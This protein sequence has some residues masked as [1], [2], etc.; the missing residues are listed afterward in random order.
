MRYEIVGLCGD[1]VVAAGRIVAT[2]A[3]SLRMTPLVAAE[4]GRPASRGYLGGMQPLRRVVAR[5]READRYGFDLGHDALQAG[6]SGFLLKDVPADQLVAGIHVVAQGDALLAPSVTRRLIHEFARSA[7]RDRQPPGSTS[8]RPASSRCSS[9]S[10]AA[11]PT[12]K[13]P[14]S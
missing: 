13:S 6:A 9:C 14:R 11:S 12:L 4:D 3:S 7:P 5:A 8:S 2:A 10:P 1:L